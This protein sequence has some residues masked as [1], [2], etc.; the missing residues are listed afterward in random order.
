MPKHPKNPYLSPFLACMF[1]FA[2][3]FAAALVAMVVFI[4]PSYPGKLPFQFYFVFAFPGLV[5]L[6]FFIAIGRSVVRAIR[7][8]VTMRNGEEDTGTFVA[9]LNSSSSVNGR[10]SVGIRFSYTNAHG[11]YSEVKTGNIFSYLQ[12]DYLSRKGTFSIKV[13]GK[14]AF[15]TEDLSPET[16][17]PYLETFNAPPPQ[18]FSSAAVYEILTRELDKLPSVEAKK[19]LLQEHI[20]TLDAETY[21]RLVKHIDINA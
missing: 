18:A 12:R 4:P 1:V 15:I 10:V 20:K 5:A 13:L 8:G 2:A 21:L 16:I 6:G 19:A 3:A 17:V 14:S 7:F 11:E 9:N